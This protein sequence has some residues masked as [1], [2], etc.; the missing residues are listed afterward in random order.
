MQESNNISRPPT[1]PLRLLLLAVCALA[2][3][4]PRSAAQSGLPQNLSN[5][6]SETISLLPDSLR[7]DSAAIVPGS[8]RLMG[9]ADTA[10]SYNPKT[11]ILRWRTKPA[12]DSLTLRYRLL[13][14]DFNKK[15]CHKNRDLVDSNFAMFVY[16]PGVRGTGNA[17]DFGDYNEL[18]YN[19]SYG[20][21]LSVGNSQDVVLNSAFNLQANGYILDSI[22]LEAAITDNAVPFQPEGNTQRL[23]EFDKIFIR[24]ERGPQS[25]Q[26]GD[27]NLEKPKGY[28]LNYFKRVQGFYYQGGFNVGKKSRNSIGLSGSVAKG[29]YARN[30]FDGKEGNQGPYKL[31]G[32]NGEQFFISAGR[33][34]THLHQ[35]HPAWSAASRPTT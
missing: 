11:Q 12:G 4:S 13:A 22:K 31:T 8:L 20:R 9:I 3:A 29:Q 18:D 5:L 14:V 21:S 15:Y 16:K 2:L 1:S 26:L 17:S 27:F 30:I 24:L 32:N 33:H 35:R 23:Q 28:F 25:L 7:L 10:Y 34:G 19:G 6:R